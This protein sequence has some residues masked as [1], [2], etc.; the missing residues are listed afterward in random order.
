MIPLHRAVPTATKARGNGAGGS[1]AGGA[2]NTAKAVPAAEPASSSGR[3]AAAKVTSEM[4]GAAAA[5]K[6]G[7]RTRKASDNKPGGGEQGKASKD[8]PAAGKQHKAKRAG[9]AVAAGAEH[10]LGE[11]AAAERQTG[12]DAARR[13]A[14]DDELERQ[15]QLAMMASTVDTGKPAA[16]ADAVAAGTAV[17]RPPAEA[18]KGRSSVAN[19]MRDASKR[20]RSSGGQAATAGGAVW[21]EVFCG[22]AS[23]GGW[24]HVDP[25]TGA[26]DAP[27]SVEA[28][29]RSGS[30][31]AYIVAF[32]D[33]GAKDVTRR[34]CSSFMKSLKERDEKWWLPVCAPLR[35]APV[36]P[37]PCPQQR[38]VVHIDGSWLPRLHLPLSTVS[39]LMSDRL[40]WGALALL[41]VPT[42][43]FDNVLNNV[44][45]FDL[46]QPQKQSDCWGFR[47][48]CQDF[49]PLYAN[50][51]YRWIGV[52]CLAEHNEHTARCPAWA[53][54]Q[55]P[56]CV[57]R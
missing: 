34:Y 21:V 29:Q 9:A 30:V 18:S 23:D 36:R 40:L 17:A 20:Q 13:Q 24:L 37:C 46:V 4:P 1:R 53:P 50:V 3:A 28:A 31:L 52:V 15:L 41:P 5:A 44:L 16:K 14:G 10:E 42:T 35:T 38:E 32:L 43:M 6:R 25:L 8:K 7:G 56:P 48:I 39:P 22:S 51:P 57:Y 33:G 49:A 55:S 26:V 2:L 12:G 45:A 19:W 11:P 27:G 47:V 54:V